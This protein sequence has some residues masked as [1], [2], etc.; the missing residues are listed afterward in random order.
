M[1]IFL[2]VITAVAGLIAT[3]RIMFRD[4]NDFADCLKFAMTP[5]FLSWLSGDLLDDWLGSWRFGIWL[6]TGAIPG[7]A[8]GWWLY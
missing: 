5:D 8:V 3:W 6:A 1:A 7:I 2:G 4:W